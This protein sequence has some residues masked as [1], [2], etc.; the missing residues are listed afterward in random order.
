MLSAQI[1]RWVTRGLDAMTGIVSNNPAAP[2]HLGTGR[3]GED[4]AYFHLQRAGYSIVARNWRVAGPKGEIDLISWDADVLC[5]IEVKT[6]TTRDVK[7]AE[8]AVDHAKQRELRAMARA[9]LRC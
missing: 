8:A 9:Y 5:F 7:P 2:H 3:R 1:V 4:E 6:R